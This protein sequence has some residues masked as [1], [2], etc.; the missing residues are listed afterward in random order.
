[1]PTVP[2][3]S[4]I[5][6]SDV[7]LTQDNTIWKDNRSY[8][9]KSGD[10][11]EMVLVMEMTRY[12]DDNVPGP[13]RAVFGF[14]LDYII[15]TPS[16]GI[17]RKAL[18]SDCIYLFEYKL[19][20]HPGGENWKEISDL[21][22]GEFVLRAI[23]HEEIAEMKKQYNNDSQKVKKIDDI[24]SMLHKHMLSRFTPKS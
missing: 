20:G 7:I 2:K 5:Y 19:L 18:P 23:G 14:L 4:W 22:D 8:S 12:E 6:H 15:L 17:V 3:A 10:A 16:G 21:E 13:L 1:M 9:L 24:E 11:F